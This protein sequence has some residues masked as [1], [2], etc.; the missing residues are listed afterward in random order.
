MV[1]DCR[2]SSR[3]PDCLKIVFSGRQSPLASSSFTKGDRLPS[4]SFTNRASKYLGNLI[5]SQH[6]PI[7]DA[8]YLFSFSLSLSLS[9]SLFLSNSLLDEALYIYL[10]LNETK[11]KSSFQ[12][13][14][15]DRYDK[16]AR[17]V[18]FIRFEEI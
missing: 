6:V 3:K 11:C 13:S 4:N 16:E 8:R 2:P 7:I 10:F 15:N 9:F 17:I 5:I 1:L 18:T 12:K 14:I